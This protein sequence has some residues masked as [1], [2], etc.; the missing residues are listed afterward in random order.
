MLEGQTAPTQELAQLLIAEGYAGLL[1]RS[2]ARGTSGVNLNL[3]L[4]R[5][6]GD[7]CSLELIDDEGRLG[8]M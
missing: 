8:R 7:G 1:T 4:W 6:S 5:W 3:V 2:F